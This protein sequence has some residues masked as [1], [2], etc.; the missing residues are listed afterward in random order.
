[1]YQSVFDHP[2]HN[3]FFLFFWGGGSPCFHIDHRRN[4]QDMECMKSLTTFF[5]LIKW[6]KTYRTCSGASFMMRGASPLQ[7]GTQST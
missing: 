1:M 2:S 7:K 6:T 4:F 5:P 3:V